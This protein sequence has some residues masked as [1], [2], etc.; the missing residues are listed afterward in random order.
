MPSSVP[1]AASALA[2]YL[3]GSVSFAILIARAKGLDL[4]QVGS[5]NAGATNAGRALGR[6]F[7]ILIY[8]LDAV[9]GALPVAVP[10]LVGW[11][12]EAAVLGGAAAYA[13]HVWPLYFGFRGG[14]GVATYSGAMLVLAPWAVLA[15][16]LVFA[17]V[18]RLSRTMAL[19]SIA[20]GLSMPLAVWI[21]EPAESL[22][23]RRAALAFAAV[24]GLLFLYTHRS[25]LARLR[26]GRES[27]LG[28]PKS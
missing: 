5:G 8:L 15:A 4:R 11:P 17:A 23:P 7:G 6:K 22:G 16:G 20:F 25:N 26:A 1:L 3:C 19:A 27:R 28:G 18:L 14:K 12:L 10:L 21:L 13:G 9:K 24:G 2:G